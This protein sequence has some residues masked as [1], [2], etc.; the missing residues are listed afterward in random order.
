MSLIVPVES[1][2]FLGV[3]IN[4]IIK[5]NCSKTLLKSFCCNSFNNFGSTQHSVVH[6]LHYVVFMFHN[7]SV[8]FVSLIFAVYLKLY[9]ITCCMYVLLFLNNCVIFALHCIF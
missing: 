7:M 6:I 2:V 8:V 3:I 9:F 1:Q 4:Y 5:C